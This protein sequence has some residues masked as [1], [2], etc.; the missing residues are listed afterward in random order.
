M[1][2]LGDQGGD[3]RGHVP[4]LLMPD[5]VQGVS[6]LDQLPDVDLPRVARVGVAEVPGPVIGHPRQ[7]QAHGRGD[8]GAGPVVGG[9]ELPDRLRAVTS[10]RAG[11]QEGLDDLPQML[12]GLVAGPADDVA[13]APAA[14]GRG[15]Q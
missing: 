3:Q 12:S 15:V 9:P 1:G 11:V 7:G 10:A 13:H 2:D 4:V 6:A 14:Q 8:R 5:Q